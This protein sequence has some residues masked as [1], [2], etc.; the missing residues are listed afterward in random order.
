[1]YLF[2]EIISLNGCFDVR[3]GLLALSGWKKTAIRAIY[4]VNYSAINEGSM[5]ADT[6][7]NSASVKNA[8]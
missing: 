8:D 4:L 5:K 7:H 3:E 2:S 1:M 6:L